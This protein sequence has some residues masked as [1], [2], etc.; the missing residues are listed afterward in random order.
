MAKGEADAKLS[1]KSR[2]TAAWKKVKFAADSNGA[3]EQIGLTPLRVFRYEFFRDFFK[4]P[5]V[6]KDKASI[7]A[8]LQT[9]ANRWESLSDADKAPYV[10]RSLALRRQHQKATS[11]KASNLADVLGNM[12][13]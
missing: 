5:N 11:M 2:R 1:L 12:K 9:A 6:P 3:K 4:N 10:A 8:F 7:D 13:M